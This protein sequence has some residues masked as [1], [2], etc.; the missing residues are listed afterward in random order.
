MAQIDVLIPAY[1]AEGTIRES[2]ESILGQTIRDIR[3]VVVN[4]GS[5]DSTGAVLDEMAGQDDR[6]LVVHQ[7]NGGIVDALNSGLD[8]CYSDFIAR[9]DA[10]DIAFPNR[11]DR[12][13]DYLR[14]H[15]DCIAVSAK[16]HIIDTN[17]TRTGMVTD[18]GDP[19]SANPGSI[20]PH[21]PHLMHPFL[22]IRRSAIEEVGRYRHVFHAEDADLYWRL[23]LLGGLVNLPDILGEYR[24]HTASVTS[25]SI[26][27]GRVNA[28]NSQLAAI[29][30]LRRRAKTPDIVFDKSLLLAYHKAR[31]LQGMVEVASTLLTDLERHR[32]ELGAVL[33]LFEMALYRPYKLELNDCVYGRKVI[34]RNRGQPSEVRKQMD[35][36]SIYISAMLMRRG[37]FSLVGAVTPIYVYPKIALHLIRAK[38]IRLLEARERRAAL[39]ER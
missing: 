27:N 20:P 29:S 19:Q 9:H 7:T 25:K 16:A 33:K 38:L 4:D 23:Q 37:E 18:H 3:I 26:L 15:P 34:A 31:S 28:I 22:M 32:L 11:F 35:L 8:H 10:D 39:K 13:L 12:E 21:E 1:N 2:L 30:E 36:L 5:T 24:I 6:I 17:G 14:G